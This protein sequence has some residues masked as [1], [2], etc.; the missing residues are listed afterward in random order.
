[1]RPRSGLSKIVGISNAPGTI[2]SD[3]RGELIIL[4]QMNET[5][6]STFKR[7][8]K[9]ERIAQIRVEKVIDTNFIEV[10]ELSETKRGTGG[11]G[12]TGK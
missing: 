4:M 7:I 3:Y 6:H 1:V 12:S 11:F 2:D 5:L 8:V 10:P 9:G